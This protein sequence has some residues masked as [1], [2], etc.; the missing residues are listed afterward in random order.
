MGATEKFQL[1]VETVARGEADL[2]RLEQVVNKLAESS[3]RAQKRTSESYTR[4][5]KQTGDALKKTGDDAKQFG[6]RIRDFIERPITSAGNAFADLASKGGKA[7]AVFG[8]I[9]LGLA[10]AATASFALVNSAS[11]A[12]REVSNLSLS[13]GLTVNQV[14]RLSAIAKLADF[15]LV[16]L[17]QASVD[18]SIALRDTG[19][20]GD[21]TRRSLRE[22]GISFS[23]TSGKFRPLGEVLNDAFEA[24]SKIDDT[25]RRVKLSSVLGGEDAA[26]RV[27][28]LVGNYQKFG[29]VV[30]KLGYGQRESIVKPLA[31]AQS[32]VQKLGLQYDLLRDKLAVPLSVVL[33][34]VNEGLA[35]DSVKS[36]FNYTYPGAFVAAAGAIGSAGSSVSSFLSPD[37]PTGQN[38]APGFPLSPKQFADGLDSNRANIAAGEAAFRGFAAGRGGQ[39]AIEFRIKKVQEERATLLNTLQQGSLGK[40]AFDSTL[41][42][43]NRLTGEEQGLQKAIARLEA[44]RQ[45][46]EI[47]LPS[48]SDSLRPRGI[49]SLLRGAERSRVV[50]A[51]GVLGTFQ[52]SEAEIATANTARTGAGA[53]F[54]SLL[55]G[56]D[57]RDRSRR[58]QTNQQELAFL[59]RKLELL[60][61]PGG[62]R[63]AIEEIAKLKLAALQEEAAVSLENFNV[64]DRQNQ[65]ERDRVISILELQ[66]K[67]RDAGRE[68]TGRTFDA[69][70]SG[71]SG[72]LGAL[73]KSVGL[74]QVRTIAQNAG[75]K[76]T[77]GA[78]GFLGRIGAASGLGKFLGGTAFDPQNAGSPL[79]TA[80]DANTVATNANT[81]ALM[82]RSIAGAA[83]VGGILSAFGRSNPAAFIPAS[84]AAFTPAGGLPLSYT[85]GGSFDAV[86]NRAAGT[87]NLQL[88]GLSSGVQLNTSPG[89]SA[90]NKGVGY[91][92]AGLAGVLGAVNGFKAGG[93]QGK[94]SAFSSIAG[95]GASIIALAGISG[96][97]APILAGIGLAL[98]ATAA[99]IGDPKK[100]RDKALDRLVSG[101]RFDETQPLDYAF[102]TRGGGFDYNSRG[103]L[104]SMPIN[105]TINAL[106]SRSILERG[107]DIA[108]AV[109]DAMY[110]GHSINRAA[111]EVVLGV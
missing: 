52:T 111:Q 16:N 63:A 44:A 42:A 3:E 98:A 20:Q 100:N 85:G 39:D 9:A 87:R 88:A 30:D 102:D 96:P 59:S 64:R 50:Q 53:G 19:G 1:I 90:L 51:G 74:S 54:G 97:A 11:A 82:G 67:Q 70:V 10:S 28:S 62:E 25:S 6:D 84:T 76:L 91:A 89:I 86:T 43:I 38:L 94:L 56:N 99:L 26:A 77:T 5:A 65:I 13:T 61:G 17:N 49:P 108:S 93:A 106:D 101:S 55:L 80:T 107:E 57:E 48:T 32:E 4:G 79:Q 31:E 105:L 33:R 73:V 110:S 95:A 27:Q 92:G 23:D 22:L 75:E 81:A 15:N 21:N 83:G 41:S 58:L 66:K 29:A 60:A 46:A 18:L 45:S 24:L 2:R 35:S 14:D 40:G 72:G 78:G 12:A 7:G 71:G 34:V 109:R 36:A 104:R 103:D 47:T 8:G 68:A 69:L 37:R